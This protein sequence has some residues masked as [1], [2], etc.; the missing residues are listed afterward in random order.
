M[1]QLARQVELKKTYPETQLVQV[2]ELMI[3]LRQEEAQDIQV[4]VVRSA[5][6]PV[7]PTDGEQESRQE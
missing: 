5:Y 4:R 7:S 2:V 6:S 1:G 3:Q